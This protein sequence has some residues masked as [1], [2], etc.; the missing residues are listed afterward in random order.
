MIL[1]V[2]L[3]FVGS[4][5]FTHV[6]P[7][8]QKALPRSGPR[9]AFESALYVKPLPVSRPA[10]PLPKDKSDFTGALSAQA[11]LVVDNDTNTVLYRK[12]ITTPR[13]LASITKLM[14]VL[15]LNKLNINWSSSTVVTSDDIDGTD[16]HLKLGER[17]TLDQLWHV[18]LVGSSNSAIRVLERM[19]G[20]TPQQFAEQM[21]SYAADLHLGTARF[22]EPTG[23]D[24]RNMAS[25]LDTARLLKAALGVDRI[26]RTL[27]IGEYDLATSPKQ[28]SRPVW[29]TNWLLT[30]W[31]PNSFERG[32]VVGK[33]GYIVDSGYNFAVR[34]R[35]QEG[36]T[37]RVIILGAESN[38]ARFAEARDL[39]NWALNQY[40]WPT[41]QGYA[42]LSTGAGHLSADIK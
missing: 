32:A 42:Q 8:P 20:L 31:V 3:L 28:K 5:K 34:L 40:V 12:N 33:T 21:N 23:L 27:E 25:A 38:E 37:V 1:G 24:S 18:A 15:V 17:Y 11:A 7:A 26:L 39:G 29:T 10:V 41:D 36:H 4:L 2:G 35:G 22:V 16:H 19:S 13:P 14:S 9:Q 6:A 30:D